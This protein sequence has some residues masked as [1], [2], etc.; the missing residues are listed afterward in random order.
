MERPTTLTLAMHPCDY[1]RL[2][3]AAAVTGYRVEDF[4]LLALHRVSEALEA[5]SAHTNAIVPV[6]RMSGWRRE[7]EN[8]SSRRRVSHSAKAEPQQDRDDLALHN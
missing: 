7:L 8:E 1:D 3:K 5:G 4:A 2:T 6:G